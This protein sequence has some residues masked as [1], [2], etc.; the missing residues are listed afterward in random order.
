MLS[1]MCPKHPLQDIKCIF[2]DGILDNTL[3]DGCDLNSATLG[4]ACHLLDS[5]NINWRGNSKSDFSS[6][7]PHLQIMVNS[8]Y[9][10]NFDSSYAATKKELGDNVILI[11][12]IYRITAQNSMYDKY[13]IK[14][15]RD[16]LERHGSSHSEQNHALYCSIIGSKPVHYFQL[17]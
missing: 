15:I 2:R 5:T 7:S 3:N 14:H 1:N 13:I 8:H 11:K 4:D 17:T 10:S 12:D 6:V 9:E 16:T